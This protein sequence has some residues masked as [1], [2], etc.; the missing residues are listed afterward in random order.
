MKNLTRPFTRRAWL[1]ALAVTAAASVG[2]VAGPGNA[3]PS[4]H[5]NYNPYPPKAA[6]FKAPKLKQGVLT[7]KGSKRSD[8]IAL[9]LQAGDAGILQ[10]DVGDDGSADFYFERSK[11]AKIT[12]KAGAGD[13]LVRI[14]ESNGAFTDS[15]PTTLA[16]GDGGPG[17]APWG[18]PCLYVSAEGRDDVSPLPL[19][20]AQ[21]TRN[22]PCMIAECGSQTKR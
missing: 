22:R 10:V 13:D 8:K 20:L 16:G 15:I 1:A 11:I 2:M 18:P 9:R 6:K 7:V 12:V 17:L 4:V 21:E 3:T 19:V 5:A 14:D